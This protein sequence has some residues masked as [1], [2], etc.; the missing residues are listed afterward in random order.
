[1]QE[2][3]FVIRAAAPSDV[4]DIHALIV[5]LA[6]YERAR[7]RVVATEADLMRALFDERATV[8]A[9]VALKEKKCVGFALYFVSYSTWTGRH[10]LWLEDLFVLPECRGEGIGKALLA[11]L[12]QLAVTRGYTRLEWNVLDWNEPALRFYRSLEAAPLSEWTVHRLDGDSLHALACSN[13][14]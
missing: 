1:M 9:Y 8:H 14:P 3:S 4:A 12:A 5:A 10:G 7:D 2:A 13:D 6:D 11:T